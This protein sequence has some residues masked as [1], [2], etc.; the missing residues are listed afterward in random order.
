[1]KTD[2]SILAALSECAH[3]PSGCLGALLLPQLHSHSN[4]DFYSSTRGPFP[5][6]CHVLAI[7]E[8]DMAFV[9]HFP[10]TGEI[11][12]RITLNNLPFPA[13][14]PAATY[15]RIHLPRGAQFPAPLWP[16][17]VTGSHAV[18]D[19]SIFTTPLN[20]YCEFQLL[21]FLHTL[22]QD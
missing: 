14:T 6:C 13:R 7:N 1:M 10:R 20:F 8:I 12:S 4:A 15:S 11:A 18:A 5:S 3:F 2:Y 22:P 19:E 16:F 21:F 17:Q 9:S